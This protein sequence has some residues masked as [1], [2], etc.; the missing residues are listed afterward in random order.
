MRAVIRRAVRLLCTA[1]AT[2]AI[3]ASASA[4]GAGEFY[5]GRTVTVVVG[6]PPG[7]SYDLL[8]RALARHMGRH[9]PGSPAM[10]VQ[11]MP[12]AGSKIAT[13][14]IYN[15]A[16]QDGTVLATISQYI[17]LGQLLE[18]EKAFDAAR[19]KWIGN[20][21]QGGNNVMAAWAATGIRTIEDVKAKEMI[22]GSTG[23]QTNTE[24]YP[25]VLN[26]LYGTRFKL[27]RGYT[28][29]APTVVAIERGELDGSA[30]ADWPGWKVFRPDWIRDR[31]INVILQIGSV[32]EKDL[33]DVPLLIEL[34]R[35]PEERQILDLV[36]SGVD[37]GRPFATGPNVPD[38][39]V[40]VLRQ[41]FQAML[42]DSEFQA[43]IAKQNIV[44]TPTS[45]EEV[46]A[47]VERTLKVAPAVAERTRAA[48]TPQGMIDQKK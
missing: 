30:S 17:A 7:G 11:N 18:Q 31:K 9:I 10:I 12:G 4:Q 14:H 41:A 1:A 26:A 24:Y 25:A 34:A 27:V 20:L 48:L 46:Q 44:L 35:N 5:K 36:T 43:E 16:A 42:K 45:G 21:G 8:A 19:L 22:V 33:P 6:Y 13:Q 2:L 32:R 40:A 38:D 3:A 37:M 28:G 29:F 23:P 15:L 47:L 39:R